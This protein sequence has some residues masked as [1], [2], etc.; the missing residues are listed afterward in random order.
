VVLR[1]LGKNLFDPNTT[2][3]E[4]TLVN[5]NG[6]E[7]GS[8]SLMCSGFIPVLP[9]TQY[10]FSGLSIPR[11]GLKLSV[12]FFDSNK[13]FIRPRYIQ[14][15][16]E[17]DPIFTT[18]LNC[19]FIRL[20]APTSRY[21]DGHIWDKYLTY[22]TEHDSPVQLEIGAAATTY[23]EYSAQDV[24]IPVDG[25]GTYTPASLPS[26][27]FGDN[28]FLLL[29]GEGITAAMSV[30]YRLDPTLVYQKLSAAIVAAGTT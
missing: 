22:G 23:E 2:F 6:V 11:S 25:A 21:K 30:T 13:T 8:V 10:S 19:C 17:K 9:N 7:A 3:K 16:A 24:T 14:N 12:T 26:T 28:T 18:P 27:V 20:N 4:K 1:R 29:P 15:P 5:D